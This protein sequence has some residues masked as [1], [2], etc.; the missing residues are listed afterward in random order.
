MAS[1][2]K[3][4]IKKY[5]I[6]KKA[7][8]VFR[9][10]RKRSVQPMARKRFKTRTRTV[11][12]TVRRGV[13]RTFSF[14]GGV[15]PKLIGGAAYGAV[16][17]PISNATANLLPGVLGRYT[18]NVVMLGLSWGASQGK[19]PLVNKIPYSR[20]MG[21]AGLY[22]ESAMLGQ[23][24]AQQFMGTGTMTSSSASTTGFGW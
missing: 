14:G 20:E 5:G 7:W 4:I 10:S 21:T 11:V 8:S 16:R 17:A 3:A 1:L 12:R 6:S 19:I 23:E 2:P 22:I 24:L 13:K 9:S 18:D 15:V